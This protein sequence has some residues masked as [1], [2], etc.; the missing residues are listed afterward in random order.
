MGEAVIKALEWIEVGEDIEFGPDHV[1][2]IVEE[3]KQLQVQCDA[4]VRQ[5]EKWV[6][7]SSIN[8]MPPCLHPLVVE[9]VEALKRKEIE[10]ELESPLV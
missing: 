7:N 10:D 3:F 9:T 1:L 6:R 2:A 4:A 8:S 5:L